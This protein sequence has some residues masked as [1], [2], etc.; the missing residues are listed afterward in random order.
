M[1]RKIIIILTFVIGLGIFSY[2]ILSNMFATSAHQAVTTDYQD[3]VNKLESYKKEDITKT[4]KKHNEKLN[5]EEMD[6]IDPFENGSDKSGNKSYYDALNIGES[7][8][9]IKVDEI[10][11]DLPIY[12]G[13]SEGVLSKGAGHLENTSLPLGNKGEHSVVTAHRGLPSSK[14]FRNVDKLDVGDEFTIQIL[15]DLMNYEIYD[16]GIVEPDET[17]WLKTD[18]DRNLVTLLSC[19][20]YMINT[21]RLLVKGELT[22]KEKIKDINKEEATV[23]SKNT[24]LSIEA[25]I[26]LAIIAILLIIVV[27]TII[28]F[29]KR[30]KEEVLDDGKE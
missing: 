1:R 11:I 13:T 21:H 27:M 23:S 15:D 4:G 29:K 8:G 30:N 3:A 26:I 25:K 16:I 24:V 19:E 28:V 14:L 9:S 10:N 12:H 2:P 6:F 20:P 17:E 22:G 18:D 7:M 5:E